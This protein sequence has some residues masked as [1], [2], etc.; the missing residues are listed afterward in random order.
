M[1]RLIIRETYIDFNMK[2][3]RKWH[4]NPVEGEPTSHWADQK[5]RDKKGASNLGI[6]KRGRLCPHI[7]AEG[8]LNRGISMK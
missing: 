4:D 1:Y 8:I 2:I 7:I 3:L 5:H 6:D